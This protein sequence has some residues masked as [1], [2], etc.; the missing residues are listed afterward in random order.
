MTLSECS[1]RQGSPRSCSAPL[2]SWGRDFNKAAALRNATPRPSFSLSSAF[3][4]SMD[5]ASY[6]GEQEREKE[7]EERERE[8]KI[9]IDSSFRKYNMLLTT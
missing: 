8:R 9:Y 1:P 6:R 3:S 7:K 2:T 4:A 5:N